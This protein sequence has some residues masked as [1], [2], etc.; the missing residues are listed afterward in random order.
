MTSTK[1]T[2]ESVP[3]ST[4]SSEILSDERVEQLLQEAETRL[5]ETSDVAL[6]PSQASEV[7]DVLTVGSVGKRKSHVPFSS[8]NMGQ[9]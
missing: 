2:L 3:H 6:L 7:E 4:E 8:S 5:R 9:C 1:S